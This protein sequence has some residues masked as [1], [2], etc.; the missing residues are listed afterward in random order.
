MAAQGQSIT[1]WKKETSFNRTNWEA[2]AVPVS[3]KKQ[4]AGRT[5]WEVKEE[6]RILK[7]NHLME[8]LWGVVRFSSIT[9]PDMI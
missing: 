3:N 9:G 7:R 8:A 2:I 5:L 6:A 4:N 1:I